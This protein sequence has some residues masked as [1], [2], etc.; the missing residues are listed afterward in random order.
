MH[1][2]ALS[3]LA[4][5]NKFGDSVVVYS[6]FVVALI[7]YGGFV[8]GA[9]YVMCLFESIQ[10]SNILAGEERA[11]CFTLIVLWLSLFSVSSSRCRGL[12]CSL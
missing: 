9:C 5:S 1:L 6:L 8:W 7:V 4:D 3:V 2:L 10:F 11:G 12:I